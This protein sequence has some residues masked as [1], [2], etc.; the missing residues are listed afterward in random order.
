MRFVI[1]KQFCYFFFLFRNN[2]LS[3]DIY[4]NKEYQKI[5]LLE[6]ILFYSQDNI[7]INYL[8]VYNF[9]N[10][11]DFLNKLSEGN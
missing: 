6:K 9:L 7:K 1:V 8:I 10:E 5:N 11:T 2:Y 3:K 4:L